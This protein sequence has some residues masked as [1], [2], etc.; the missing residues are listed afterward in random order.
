MNSS[1]L[2]HTFIF[3]AA[4]CVIV[5]IAGRFKLGSVLGYLLAG[6]L[7]GPFGL[8][9][10]GNFEQVMHFAEFGVV[11]ML[12]IIGLELEPPTLWQ[13]RKAIVGLGGL[14]VMVTITAFTLIGISFGYGWRVSLAAGMALSLSSTALVPSS[15][16][17][18]R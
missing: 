2:F 8:G 4:A 7:I 14:Q 11:V 17:A 18:P 12:F 3:L 16:Q 10:I 13:L 5:P 15:A 9:F 6:V 1:F